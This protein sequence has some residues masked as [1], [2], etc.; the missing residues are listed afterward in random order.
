MEA[1]SH[2]PAANRAAVMMG[3]GSVFKQYWRLQFF[4]ELQDDIKRLWEIIPEA[5]NDMQ[6]CTAGTRTSSH[7]RKSTDAL[8]SAEKRVR[9]FASHDEQY[10]VLVAMNV[11][12]SAVGLL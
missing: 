1:M 3:E 12:K 2:R 9:W 10:P 5:A 4:E 7:F 11:E 8:K 6:H